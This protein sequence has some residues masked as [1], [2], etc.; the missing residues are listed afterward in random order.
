MPSFVY[1]DLLKSARDLGLFF[2][3]K[4]SVATNLERMVNVFLVVENLI[5]EE[6][7]SIIGAILIATEY[8]GQFFK[9]LPI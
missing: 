2:R 9:L 4:V 5:L 6:I 1:C 8:K 3:N 7:L